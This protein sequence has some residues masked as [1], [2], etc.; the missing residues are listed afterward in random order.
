MAS[1]IHLSDGHVLSLKIA[2]GHSQACF[3]KLV[4][5]F[6]NAVSECFAL[7]KKYNAKVVNKSDDVSDIRNM[8]ILRILKGETKH[9]HDE[10]AGDE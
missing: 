8:E 2:I 1:M 10:T 3:T 6:M 4:H 7:H 5:T 9:D